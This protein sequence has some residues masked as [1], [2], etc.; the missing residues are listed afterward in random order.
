[1]ES[2]KPQSSRRLLLTSVCRP[3]GPRHGDGTSVGYELLHGQVTRAQGMFSPRSHQ[4]HFSLEY[5]AHNLDIPTVVLQY[6][7]ER[8]LV[9]ELKKGYEYVGVSFILAT[10]HKMKRLVELIRRHAPGSKI[11]LGGYGT[12]LTDQELAPYG[13][14]FC[15]E[16]GVGF[17]RRLL[18]EPPKEMPYDH[19]I[20]RNGLKVFSTSIGDN[21][22]IFAGLGCP[23]GC[24]F[25][26]TSHFFKRKH[27][28]LLP[29]GRDIFNVLVKYRAAHPDIKF[30]VLDEDF[31]L[32]KKRAL[33]Y[34]EC[35][36]T[37]GLDLPMFV[38]GSVK[39]LSQY[40]MEEILEM[41]ISGVWMGY[42]GRRSNY[43]KQQGR[44]IDEL[45]ADLRANGINVLAS[46]IVGFDYQSP[47]IIQEELDSLLALE[48][49]FAQFLIYGPVPGTPF[50]ERI[51]GEG[52]LRRKFMENKEAFYRRCTGFYNCVKHPT[53]TAPQ[54]QRIQRDCFR[55]D[56]ERLGPSIVRAMEGWWLG[57]HR[58]K[59]HA[60]E[61]LRTC[62]ER[63]R[64]DLINSAP[65][66]RPAMLLGPTKAAR[67]RARRL[68]EGI[69]D[70]LGPM[71]AKQKVL[72]WLA[73]P[74]AWWTGLTLK[75]DLF[76]HPRLVRTEY[77][78]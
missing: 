48:P 26:C 55:Q 58:L 70:S 46:M 23:N 54:V 45:I 17:L 7:N 25:C 69:C 37:S 66:L 42:E 59:N 24:D 30:T 31:L 27:I 60:N 19:P 47:E 64:T 9:R 12:I 49:T 29:T 1:M 75:L 34:L 76:Q 3:L 40:T 56:F 53:M 43:A 65:A 35:V 21:G 74:M 51:I 73:V 28:R 10:F 71:P 41:G 36:K 78:L 18:G 77:R 8:E 72:S 5:I 61:R 4:V 68:W 57:Y 22:M 6:P 14:Y 39:A 44:P 50:Y 11:V 16:E 52:R 33:E 62:A 38:F 63:Y 32:N 20:I 13:D 15:R 67:E 2:L